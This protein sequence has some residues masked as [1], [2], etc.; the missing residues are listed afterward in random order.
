MS[1]LLKIIYKAFYKTRNRKEHTKNAFVGLV[2]L[3]LTLTLTICFVIIMKKIFPYLSANI[4]KMIFGLFIFGLGCCV[5]FMC[6]RYVN[7]QFQSEK[8]YNN[9]KHSVLFCRI[10]LIIIS[11]IGVLYLPGLGLYIKLHN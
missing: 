2:T 6:L 11:I 9:I 7:R 3:Y 8:F 1:I 4:M 10:I 5:Y